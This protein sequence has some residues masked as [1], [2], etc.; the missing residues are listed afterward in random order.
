MRERTVSKL[1]KEAG[2]DLQSFRKVHAGKA[3]PNRDAQFQ[4]I[5]RQRERFQNAG[6]PTISVD[7]KKKNA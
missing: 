6:P 5:A 7:T 4:R 3:H 1:L 2:Y